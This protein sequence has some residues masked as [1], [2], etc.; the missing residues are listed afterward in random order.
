MKKIFYL[1]F[2]VAMMGFAFMSFTS[3]SNDD[4]DE[5]VAVLIQWQIA[6]P[7]DSDEFLENVE[8]TQEQM[9]QMVNQCLSTP[10][11]SANGAAEVIKGR[12]LPLLRANLSEHDLQ[13]AKRLN[14]DMLIVAK[15]T[16]SNIQSMATITP[17]EIR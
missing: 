13:L 10:L 5:Q 9:Q 2:A 3:C 14:V 1:L 15:G 16:V 11:T 7:A 8:M 6:D 17:D 12:M 4:V